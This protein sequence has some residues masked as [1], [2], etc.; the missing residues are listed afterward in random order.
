[1]DSIVE[2][3][4]MVKRG[5]GVVSRPTESQAI[6]AL[7]NKNWSTDRTAPNAVFGQL[8]NQSFRTDKIQR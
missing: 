3:R 1:M 7:T 6:L 8:P 2:S 4:D 5:G